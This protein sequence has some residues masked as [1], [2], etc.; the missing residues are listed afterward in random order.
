M[1]LS[2]WLS[3]ETLTDWTVKYLEKAGLKSSRAKA[4]E[5]NESLLDEKLIQKCE[6]NYRPKRPYRKT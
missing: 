1:E 3:G 5:V 4:I 2:D 6:K